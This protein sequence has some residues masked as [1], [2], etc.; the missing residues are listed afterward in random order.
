MI[1]DQREDCATYIYYTLN[2]DFPKGKYQ[3]IVGIDAAGK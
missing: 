1:M 3:M 2:S